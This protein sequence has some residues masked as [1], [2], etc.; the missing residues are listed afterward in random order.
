MLGNVGIDTFL[1]HKSYLVLFALVF[2]QK[3]LS[4][5]CFVFI[6]KKKKIIE[7]QIKIKNQYCLINQYSQ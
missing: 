1:K 2:S 4:F 7:R 5:T 6:I 3:A